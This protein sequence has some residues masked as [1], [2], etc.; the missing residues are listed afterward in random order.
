MAAQQEDPAR[1]NPAMQN[2]TGMALVFT[3]TARRTLKRLILSILLALLA[4]WT[5][6]ILA[7]NTSYIH[8]S[9]SVAALILMACYRDFQAHRIERGLLILCW[10]VWAY[11]LVISILIA[12][13]RTPILVFVPCL[14]MINAWVQ[15][16]RSMLVMAA[17][18]IVF[19]C[20]LVFAEMRNW[21]PPPILRDP[22]Q[23]LLVY[24]SIILIC[25]VVALMIAENFRRLIHSGQSLSAELNNT[26]IDLK[27]S[28]AALRD[29]NEQLEQ[30]VIERTRQFDEANKSL[31][32]TVEKLELAQAELVSSEKLAS[33][34]SM[35]AG[36][37]HELNTPIGN[38]LTL[39]T[40]M[41]NKY[42][43]LMDDIAHGHLKR[44]TLDEFVRTGNEMAALATRSTK[45]AVELVSSFK[46]VAVDQTSEQRRNF[47]LRVVIEDN[48]ATLWPSIKNRKDTLRIDN[49]VAEHILCDSYPG[50]LGQVIIN[51]AQ[52]AILHGLADSNHGHISIN[53][54]ERDKL[55][56]VT[57]TDNGIGMPPH[58]LAHIFDP[59]FTTKLGKG[60]SGLG[61][62]VSYRIV[63][64]VL[65]GTI[66]AT[67][68]PGNGAEFSIVFPKTAPFKI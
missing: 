37:S 38:V 2:E 16:K 24:S 18:S 34:G 55:V 11:A 4:S 9:L 41:E 31:Q 25:S 51:L 19:L 12:G 56:N 50:P 8:V 45:R 5:Y 20:V 46:Q 47:D 65:G 3:D 30:R 43:E 49:L 1:L 35:V 53:A 63:T 33:L 27:E 6:L 14:I 23:I 29:L 67:S 59:F 54:I 62:S 66:S 17:L 22:P 58:I 13:I 36:I 15:G 40:S 42:Q 21:L 64:S 52:N 10:G 26:I 32:K 44:S 68:S 28:D 48:I 60:G 57:V 61:L 39:T 7:G